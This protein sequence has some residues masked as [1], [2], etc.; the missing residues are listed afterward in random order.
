MAARRDLCEEQLFITLQQLDDE[1]CKL[2]MKMLLECGG[3]DLREENSPRLKRR[4][5]TMLA[6]DAICGAHYRIFEE[7]AL[8]DEAPFETQA[9][10]GARVARLLRAA[11]EQIAPL[12]MPLVGRLVLDERPHYDAARASGGPAH[13][14]RTHAQAPA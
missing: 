13:A 9:F 10:P 5:G 11:G 6:F 7:G 4:K 14:H 1:A 3:A 8:V 12:L 2:G